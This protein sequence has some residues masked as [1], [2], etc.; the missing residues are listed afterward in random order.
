MQVCAIAGSPRRSGN[1]A[2]LLSHALEVIERHGIGTELVSLA[3]K[4]VQTCTACGGCAGTGKCVIED[5]FDPVYRKMIAADALIIGS[6]VY[7]G[8][9]TGE[10][11]ALLDRAGTVANG[12]GGLFARKIGGP[13]VIAR[14]AGQNFTLM[15]L[16]SWFMIN[17]F[18][19]PG[20][21][22]WNIAF[23]LNAGDVRADEEGMRTIENFAENIAWLLERIGE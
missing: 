15:Q 11:A 23:G 1:T 22:Y 10:T 18:V 17:G 3:G 21:T 12:N 5:D 19:V 16:M 20:S 8:S 13:V 7:Y 6:P 4:R 14:R 2:I 9:A